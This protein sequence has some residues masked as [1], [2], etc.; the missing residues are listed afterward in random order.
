MISVQVTVILINLLVGVILIYGLNFANSLMSKWPK[1]RSGC[2]CSIQ[3]C[4][5]LVEPLPVN[6]LGPLL[7]LVCSLESPGCKSQWGLLAKVQKVRIDYIVRVFSLSNSFDVCCFLFLVFVS[8]SFQIQNQLFE[9]LPGQFPLFLD[10]L[11][12]L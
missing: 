10:H 4:S 8:F 1:N 7:V 11:F 9:L 3:R 6:S 5:G 12:L 2:T